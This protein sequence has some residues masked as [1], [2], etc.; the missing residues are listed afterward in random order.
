MPVRQDCSTCLSGAARVASWTPTSTPCSPA[1]RAIVVARSD[2]SGGEAVFGAVTGV[3]SPLLGDGVAEV[4]AGGLPVLGLV[5]PKAAM[6]VRTTVTTTSNMPR[7][8]FHHQPR[9]IGIGC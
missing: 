7:G 8:A 5:A 1:M 9:R 3:G 4:G 2:K 6:D